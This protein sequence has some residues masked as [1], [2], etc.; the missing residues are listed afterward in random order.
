M[1]LV[2]AMTWK[3][4][5]ERHLRTIEEEMKV[6]ARCISI[7]LQKSPEDQVAQVQ[8]KEMRAREFMLINAK[9]ACISVT[10]CNA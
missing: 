7:L 5:V 3:P 6:T 8:L 9:K 10:G 4:S 2:R 1:H